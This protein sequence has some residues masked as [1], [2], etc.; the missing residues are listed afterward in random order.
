MSER[1]TRRSAAA[2]RSSPGRAIIRPRPARALVV[3]VV[4]DLVGPRPL[5]GWDDEVDVTPAEA[6][7][8]VI[9]RTA[10]LQTH[11]PELITP[12][13]CRRAILERADR[14]PPVQARVPNGHRLLLGDAAPQKARQRHP[15]SV[16]AGQRV[17]LS[18]ALPGGRSARR[19]PGF[20]RW[21]RTPDVSVIRRAGRAATL[22]PAA[23]PGPIR[24]VR[25]PGSRSGSGHPLQ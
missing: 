5:L 20:T 25:V 19:A 4:D 2:P 6:I 23:P 22:R 8:R 16:R 18:R 15:T 12:G 17:R 3:E 11:A 13:Q 1:L 9:G 24:A 21:R 10:G 7:E 14:L